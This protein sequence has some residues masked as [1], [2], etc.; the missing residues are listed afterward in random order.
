[1]RIQWRQ[2][3]AEFKA[4]G[5][6]EASRGEQYMVLTRDCWRSHIPEDQHGNKLGVQAS[7]ECESCLFW[8]SPAVS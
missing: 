2:H 6:V 5:T 4:R 7:V 3:N 8:T 1:M